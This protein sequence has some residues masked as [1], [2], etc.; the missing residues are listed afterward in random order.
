M[1]GKRLICKVRYL[2]LTL[3]LD[4]KALQIYPHFN[5][6][7]FGQVLKEI[8]EF[9][10]FQKQL[11][12]ALCIPSLYAALDVISQ[13]FT[14]LS[15]PH[16]CNT[17][18]ILK[19][20]PSLSEERQ[21]NLTLPVNEDG[22]FESCIMFTPVGSDLETFEASGISNTTECRNGWNYEV[23]SGASSIVTA[24]SKQTSKFE[25]LRTPQ[26]PL[27]LCFEP[28]NTGHFPAIIF[29]LFFF[30]FDLVCDKSNLVEASQSIY[31]AG[32]LVGALAFGP[33]S[34]R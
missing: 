30:Q 10:L 21:R 16:H 27:V 8:G 20:E 6:T 4:E 34:D 2:Y 22:L 29:V 5:M 1:L 12:V 26:N 9:G 18:W 25:T 3:Y 15:F 17:D 31:M 11:V 13:V 7:T 14:G 28:V 33:I 24:V 23:P 32:F 19:R